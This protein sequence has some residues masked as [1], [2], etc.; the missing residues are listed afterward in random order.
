MANITMDKENKA[1][2]IREL[3]LQIFLIQVQEKPFILI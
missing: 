1:V 3:N 2:T